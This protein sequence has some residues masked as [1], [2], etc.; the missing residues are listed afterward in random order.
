VRLPPFNIRRYFA[1]VK[2]I[3]KTTAM[4]SKFTI[5]MFVL[6]I[7]GLAVNAQQ[8]ISEI[9]KLYFGNAKK[10]LKSSPKN[11]DQ[12]KHLL[13]AGNHLSVPWISELLF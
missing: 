13:V 3:K 2:N 7:L 12:F 9:E 5:T 10:T 6:I 4:K 11:S 1:S 8:K